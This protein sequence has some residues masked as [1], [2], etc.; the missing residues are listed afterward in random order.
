MRNLCPACDVG[1]LHLRIVEE[2][3]EYD[4]ATIRVPDIRYSECDACGE[5]VVLPDQA[6]H[7]D[8]AYADAK[9]GHDGLLR[10]HEIAA[11]RE[12][13]GLTQQAASAMLGGGVNAFSKYERGETLQSKAM[14]LLMRVTDQF[15]EVKYY[16]AQKANVRPS[17]SVLGQSAMWATIAYSNTHLGTIFPTVVDA[18][19]SGYQ[20]FERR[21][22]TRV[23]PSGQKKPKP[24]EQAKWHIAE[25][26]VKYATS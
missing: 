6:K 4:R 21:C 25:A 13:C 11:W 3:L 19:A 2:S 24:I 9:R 20:L 18:Y 15:P 23:Q 26:P 8:V 17:N 16:L 14:D 10:S 12:R 22:I 1:A 5:E 7:N